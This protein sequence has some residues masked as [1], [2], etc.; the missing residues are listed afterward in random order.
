MTTLTAFQLVTLKTTITMGEAGSR[1]LRKL[2]SF[3]RSWRALFVTGILIMSSIFLVTMN[4][5]NLPVSRSIAIAQGFAVAGI[6]WNSLELF[7]TACSWLPC[8][9]YLTILI[10]AFITGCYIVIAVVYKAGNRGCEGYVDTP[11]GDV[12]SVDGMPSARDSCGMQRAN[13]ILSIIVTIIS[14]GCLIMEI[15]ITHSKRGR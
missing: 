10:E 9:P 5:H 7:F 8:I 14:F 12:K 4:S 13:F 2:L 3:L 15:A 6:V 11:F 1:V